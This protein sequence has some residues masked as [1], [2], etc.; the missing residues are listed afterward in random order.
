MVP[1]DDQNWTNDPFR[2]TERDGRLYG[3]GATDMKGY[4]GVLPRGGAGHAGAPLKKPLHLAFSYDEEVGCWG[5]RR[6][7][8]KIA[9]AA[10]A[11]R[12][13]ASSASRPRWTS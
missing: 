13:P 11:S 7:I 3:R 4:P 1:V 12:S 8:A 9:D 10:G 5:V 2:L 6:M